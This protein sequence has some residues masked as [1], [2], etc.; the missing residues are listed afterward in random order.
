[1]TNTMETTGKTR[2][3]LEQAMGV[4]AELIGLLAPSCERIAV[5]G[6][7]RRGR[8]TVGD[9]ELVYISATVASP[10]LFGDMTE[11]KMEDAICRLLSD[12]VLARRRDRMFAVTWG[13]VNKLAVH[14]ASGIPVD[15]FATTP[16]CW[17]N[18]MV[19]RTGPADSNLAIAR[20]A[21]RRGWKW[22]PYGH[23]FEDARGEVIVVKSEREVFD[24]LGL[25]P[26]P[27]VQ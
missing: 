6:S 17:H 24:L 3:P 23:G 13:A 2:W 16:G 27:W 9:I 15:L 21:M 1:M 12:G 20:A 11:S 26:P 19:C 5:A 10:S 25:P 8:P 18:Y 14:E 22:T 4:A 7:V